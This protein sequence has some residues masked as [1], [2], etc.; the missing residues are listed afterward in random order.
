MTKNTQQGVRTC[1][2]P[3]IS[4]VFTT[5]DRMLRYNRSSH[6]LFSDTLI[7]GSFSKRGKQY[8]QMYGASF[9]WVR[10]FPIEKIGDTHETLSILVKRDGVPP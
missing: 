3:S 10:S 7:D 5:N 1:L 4:L 6:A 2:T 8:A 9:G